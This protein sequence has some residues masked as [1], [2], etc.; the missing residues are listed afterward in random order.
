[1]VQN[2]DGIAGS[3]KYLLQVIPHL[4]KRGFDIEFLVLHASKPQIGINEFVE[5]IKEINLTTYVIK[6]GVKGFLK[7]KSLIEKGNYDIVHTH[8]IHADFYAA[9]IKSLFGFKSQLYSTKHGYSEDYFGK[10]GFD[11]VEVRDLYYY[12]SRFSEK[13]ITKSFAVSYG[14]KELFEAKG[15][16][17]QDS[18][19][20]IHHAFPLEAEVYK[21]KQLADKKQMV[22]C[23]VGRFTYLKGH[24]I[25]LE[26]C[27]ILKEKAI[28]F[29]LVFAGSGVLKQ[30]IQNKVNSLGLNKE[31][32]FIG[33]H[34]NPVALMNEC[35]IVLVPSRAEG[36]GLVVLEA[37]ASGTPVIVND[38][39][40]INEIVLHEQSGLIFKRNDSKDLAD[41]IE[42]LASNSVLYNKLSCNAN[43]HLIEKYNFS[44]MIERL[45]NFYK[46]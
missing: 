28:S 27:V 42:Q 32:E 34:S 25:A 43:K 40:A 20:V 4:I 46:A 31:V 41:K 22:I 33:Y 24:D 2:I 30:E 15:I 1:M 36:F 3:E 5:K 6:R 35:D 37:F 9:Q 12:L 29:K 8:L 38:V 44:D 7:M 10:Y 21:T 19:T 16:S 23:I 26:S 17:K 18:L 39:P 13:Y 45:V 11:N 14:L